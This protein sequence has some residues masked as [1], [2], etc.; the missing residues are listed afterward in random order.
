MS[1]QNRSPDCFPDGTGVIKNPPCH[2]QF[3]LPAYRKSDTAVP[4]GLPVPWHTAQNG[5]KMKG[6][7]IVTFV[8]H[9]LSIKFPVKDHLAGGTINQINCSLRNL[10]CLLIG[11]TEN[12]T[13]NR[14][15]SN[16]KKWNEL[17]MLTNHASWG[18]AYFGNDCVHLPFRL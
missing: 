13:D 6:I 14:K 18:L 15:C 9:Q 11:S 12:I 8:I 5:G 4:D 2:S 7:F 17:F 16:R 1:D 10:Y 3:L